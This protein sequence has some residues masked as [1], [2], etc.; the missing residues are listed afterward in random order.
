MRIR[1]RSS[2]DASGNSGTD[3]EKHDLLFKTIR[4][5]VV[6]LFIKDGLVNESTFEAVLENYLKP[7]IQEQ[8]VYSEFAQQPKVRNKI[9]KIWSAFANE[10]PMPLYLAFLSSGNQFT[11]GALTDF[12][13]QYAQKPL[14]GPDFVGGVSCDSFRSVLGISQM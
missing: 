6:F 10:V 9:R 14:I 7:K 3:G 11:H 13:F 8:I 12:H 2:P 1:Y 5:L 4:S